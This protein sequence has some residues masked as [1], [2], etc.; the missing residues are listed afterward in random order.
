MKTSTMTLF[1]FASLALIS[2]CGGTQQMSCPGDGEPL[3]CSASDLC[4]NETKAYVECA[5]RNSPAVCGSDGKTDV[6]KAEAAC[7]NE[8]ALVAACLL[9]QGQTC[10][11]FA[12]KDFVFVAQP[13]GFAADASGSAKISTLDSGLGGGITCQVLDSSGSVVPDRCNWAGLLAADTVSFGPLSAG[14]Y[15][16]SVT[17]TFR[18]C[19]AR[20][21]T[22]DSFQVTSES[23][24]GKWMGSATGFQSMLTYTYDLKQDGSMSASRQT[25][26]DADADIFAGCTVQRLIAGSWAVSS[27]RLNFSATSGTVERTGC[28]SSSDDISPATA[29]TSAEVAQWNTDNSG[30]FT[31]TPGSPKTLKISSTEAPPTLNLQ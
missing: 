24:L 2:A 20:T 31:I 12:K 27:G 6:K 7:P 26:K 10:D 29:L 25:I 5:A 3:T 30:S 14:T 21:I 15:K 11:S 22:S 18:S 16:L 19:A 1:A 17:A 8:S 23:P 4:C 28:A 13:Q 9:T